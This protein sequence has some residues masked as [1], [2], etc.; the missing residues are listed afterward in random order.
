MSERIRVVQIIYSFA[1]A[2]TGGGAARFG[3][4]LSRRLDPRRFETV[5][6]GLWDLQ[7]PLEREQM[8]QLDAAG[9]EAFT[10]AGWEGDQPAH[11]FWSTSAVIMLHRRGAADKP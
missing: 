7:T 2:A 10:A 6:C 11:S 9:I 4:E 8:R 5:V 3:M 1:V